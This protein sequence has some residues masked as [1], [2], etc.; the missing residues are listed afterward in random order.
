MC[1]FLIHKSMRKAD[2]K[3]LCMTIKKSNCV[4]VSRFVYLILGS[5]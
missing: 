3:Y 1:L 2:I 5:I 4:Y